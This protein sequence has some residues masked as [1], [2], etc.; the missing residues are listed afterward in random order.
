MT[1]GRRWEKFE[2]SET[3]E[4]RLPCAYGQV[5]VRH[6][7]LSPIGM[8]FGGINLYLYVV[9]T[10]HTTIGKHLAPLGVA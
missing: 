3:H 4:R 7:W 1:G 10:V 9:C 2:A 8:L 5:E 6:A